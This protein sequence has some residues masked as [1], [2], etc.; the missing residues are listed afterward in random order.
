M[1]LNR[2]T[3]C[4]FR[5]YAGVHHVD[6]LPRIKYGATRPIILVGG[7]NGAGKTTLLMAVKLALHGRH[8]IG[9]GTSKTRY[10]QFIRECI[11]SPL[12]AA[13]RPSDA[14]VEL[15]FTYGKLGRHH[16]YIV[17][18]NWR[19]VGGEVQETLTLEEEGSVDAVLSTTDC[20]GFLNELVPLSVSDLF[21]F[22]G[23]KIANLAEDDTGHALGEALTRLLGLDLVERLRGD[24]RVYI[25]RGKAKTETGPVSEQIE[26]MQR[27]YEE[28]IEGLA[29]RRTDLM[30]AEAKRDQLITERERLELRLAERGG[31]WARSRQARQVE[32]AKVAEA[33]RRDERDLRTE[34]AGVYPLALAGEMLQRALRASAAGLASFKERGENQ[35]LLKFASALKSNL[36]RGAHT[37]IDFVLTKMLHPETGG[38]EGN[39]IP[40]L[41]E[42]ALG[43]MDRLLE[44]DVPAAKNR[45]RRMIEALVEKRNE[46]KHLTAEMERAPDQASLE[47]EFSAL[48]SLN[49][50][51]VDASTDVAVLTRE[52]RTEYSKAIQLARSLRNEHNARSAR[53]QL[54]DPL[55]FAA[56][57]RLLLKDFQEMSAGRKVGLLEREFVAAFRRLMEKGIV[58]DARVDPRRF[59][60]TLLNGQGDEVRRSQL[61]AGE[62]QIY[63]IAMLEAL[64]R[65][66]GRRL[67]VI[68]DTPLGRLDSRHRANLVERYFPG[69]SHQVIL[70]STDTE[71]DSSF[72]RSLSRHVSHAYLILCDECGARLRQGYFWRE[73][74]RGRNDSA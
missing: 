57:T 2:L 69:A 9:V 54:N 72:F 21:F 53:E 1:I 66:S 61:S 73:R 12:V 18:R 15:D 59:T 6:L 22:D 39:A 7:L 20:Q 60:V 10:N 42:R 8:A 16:R 55:R 28:R 17:R 35:M 67:P 64:A 14:F 25:L 30:A 50:S 46:L 44:H 56:G 48:A 31:D 40:D 71:L 49:G 52:L 43:R 23:E 51:I 34:L 33:L 58:T 70:L 45:A 65:I 19:I 74:R 26:D 38:S 63:A 13:V 47:S 37:S 36:D 4:N 24:L 29:E 32:A 68:I 5:A 41:S 27:R 11:H 62:K 3:L